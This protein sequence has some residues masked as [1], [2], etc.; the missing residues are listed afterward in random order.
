[1]QRFSA[2]N[3]FEAVVLAFNY[4]LFLPP[5]VLLLGTPVITVSLVYGNDPS[6][7]LI[8]NGPPSI[9]LTGTLVLQPVIGGMDANDYLVVAQC[10]TTNNYWT[11]ALPAVLPV[12]SYPSRTGAP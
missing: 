8:I 1:M 5:G 2:K 7:A 10:P 6:P 9:D 3:P 11:P 12:R 4:V